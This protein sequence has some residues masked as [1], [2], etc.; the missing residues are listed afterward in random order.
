M[1]LGSNP[2]FAGQLMAR[3]A[4]ASESGN[5]ISK[6]EAQGAVDGAVNELLN[7]H[8]DKGN[9]TGLKK[10][11]QQVRNTF[12]KALDSGWVRGASARAIIE[13][14]VDNTFDDAVKDIRSEV[15]AENPVSRGGGY[16]RSSYS[17]SNYSRYSGT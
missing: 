3:L 13:D 6:K 11:M 17:A 14:F 2:A 16:G 12:Q 5:T 8:L 7:K 1:K 10:D 15:R 9:T 4:T